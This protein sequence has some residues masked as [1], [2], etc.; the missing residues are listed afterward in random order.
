MTYI[1][2]GELV[3]EILKLTLQNLAE[4][5]NNKQ[6]LASFNHQIRQL[7]NYYLFIIIMVINIAL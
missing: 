3:R 7:S 5:M 1:V 4:L 2:Y 6:N